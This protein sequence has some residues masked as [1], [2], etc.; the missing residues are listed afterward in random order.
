MGGRR[1]RRTVLARLASHVQAPAAAPSLRRLGSSRRVDASIPQI[2]P[3]CTN[4][5]LRAQFEAEGFLHIAGLFTPLEAQQMEAE[6]RRFIEVVLPT[7]TVGAYYH[8][9]ADPSTIFQIDTIADEAYFDTLMNGVR[10]ESKVNDVVEV[11]FGERA[12]GLVHFFDRIAGEE[13]EHDTPPH[14]DAAYSS[15]LCTACESSRPLQLIAHAAPSS[16]RAC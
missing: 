15:Q 3:G 14:Q 6:L 2:T 5:Q 13:G 12:V 11:L 7:G 4:E 9:S 16:S 10:G 1:Q 8:D